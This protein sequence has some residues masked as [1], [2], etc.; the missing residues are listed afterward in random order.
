MNKIPCCDQVGIRP[1]MY[2]VKRIKF[3]A[4]SR[5]GLGPPCIGLNELNSLLRAG[6][7]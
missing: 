4:E 3:P 2:R 6:E 5:R 1:A 7:D